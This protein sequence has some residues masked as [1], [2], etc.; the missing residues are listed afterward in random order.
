MTLCKPAITVRAR[1][2]SNF[3]LESD[4]KYYM[5]EEETFYPLNVEYFFL[6]RKI[7]RGYKIINACKIT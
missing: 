7:G 3:M 5:V 2:R 1:K 4:H 6:L